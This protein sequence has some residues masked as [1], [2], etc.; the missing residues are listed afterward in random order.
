MSIRLDKKQGDVQVEKTKAAEVTYIRSA[1]QNSPAF[2]L[3]S[4]YA[5]IT[6]K[7]DLLTIMII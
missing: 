6:P 3:G 7:N 5:G 4:V 2:T 1:T